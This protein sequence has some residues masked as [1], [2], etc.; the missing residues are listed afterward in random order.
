VALRRGF[1]KEANAI[2][3]EIRQELSLRPTEPLKPLE[4][5]EHLAIPVIPL[6]SFEREA[7]SMVR[8][9]SFVDRSAFSA[10]TVFH[11][12][13]RIIVH[14]DRHSAGRQA[15]NLAHELSHG[16]LLHPPRPALDGRGC[17]DWDHVEELEADW[18]AGTI[19]VPDEAAIVIA[20]QGLSVAQAAELYGVSE[21]MMTF[22]LNVT[23]ARVRVARAR[24]R[25]F[26]SR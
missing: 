10:I 1:K 5:A 12:T 11:G 14:N 21:Q 8:Q 13:K 7:P 26:G 3:V 15:S 22:R 6:S 20:R 9:F 24:A 17:R 18:L 16:L 2:A 25:R 23:A 19:L 4:L